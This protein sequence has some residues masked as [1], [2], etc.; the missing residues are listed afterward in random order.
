VP[1][2]Q[3]LAWLSLLLM[4]S[5]PLMWSADSAHAEQDLD[6]QGA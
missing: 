1:S 2:S 5:A 3:Q 4:T 6:H